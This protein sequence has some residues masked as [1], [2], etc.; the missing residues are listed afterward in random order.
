MEKLKNPE[1][2]Q[3]LIR[4]VTCLLTYL[5][6]SSGIEYGYFPTRYDTLVNYIY[7]YFAYT[8]INLLS[9]LWIPASTPRRYVTLVFDIST[10]T[11]SS[12]ISVGVDSFY[13]LFYIWIYI[14]YSTR[15]GQRYLA[16]A[17]FFTVTGYS[18]LLFTEESWNLLTIVE[19]IAFL[20][21]I[22][23]LPMYLHTLQKRLMLSTQQAQSDSEAKTEFL[24]N[25]AYQIRTPIGGVVGMVDLL[26]KTDLDMQQKQYLQ[27]LSQSSHALQEIIDDIV[28]FSHIE[29]GSLP[30]NQHYSNPRSLIDSLVHSLAPL[31]YEKNMDLNCF[32]DESFPTTVMID[33]QRLRQLLSNLIR[34]VIEHGTEPGIYINA[35]AEKNNTAQN[36][37]TSIEISYLQLSGDNQLVS[38]QI[39]NTSEA[40][41]L[42]ITSQLTRLMNGLFEIQLKDK[43]RVQFNLHFNWQQQEEHTDVVAHFTQDK[44]VLIY[45]TNDASREILEKYCQQ[46][47][48]KIYATSGH[49]NLLAHIIWSIEKNS[50]FDTIILGDSQKRINC[51]E[52]VMQ[53][54]NEIKCNSPI[55]YAT[56][57]HSPDPA[58]AG[59]LQDVQ[60]TIIKPVSLNILKSTLT[61]LISAPTLTDINPLPEKQTTLSILIAEDNEINASVA[62]SYLAGMGHNVDIATDGTTA[63]YAMHKHHYHLVL[64]DVYMPNTNGIEATKQWRSMEKGKPYTP[65]VALTAKATSEERAR[66]LKAGMDD[67]LT[68]PINEN[69]LKKVLDTYAEQAIR[70]AS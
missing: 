14:A 20:L 3:S 69:Q 31:C 7:V 63:L 38:E 9:I 42:R 15:Y 49:D 29:K 24:S 1:F 4:L 23:T 45:D 64:M 33:T 57:L 53:I 43:N 62:Y 51:H 21:L 44:R 11:F 55:L 6:I 39:S 10:T 41:P 17:A 61:R 35:Y 68:K 34:Y 50:P 27:S 56:Y 37:N 47:G 2:I 5:Y 36:L 60:A 46:L 65:I 19:S 30:L 48:L 8:F 32:I 59:A 70:R 66:C 52:L 12:Y 22:V 25:M 16:V 58:E 28:D 40:L 18:F 13:V 54:R 26:S 67:F